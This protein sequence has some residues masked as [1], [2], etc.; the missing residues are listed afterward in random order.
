MT[1]SRKIDKD[2]SGTNHVFKHE[3]MIKVQGQLVFAPLRGDFLHRNC[4]WD[5]VT[6]TQ[7]SKTAQK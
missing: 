2:D 7:I 4:K 3:S 6:N 5:F 1:K